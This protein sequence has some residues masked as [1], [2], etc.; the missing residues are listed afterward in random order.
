MAQGHGEQ[1]RG[2]RG[3]VLSSVENV[4]PE[5]VERHFHKEIILLTI[6]HRKAR[7]WAVA[8]LQLRVVEHC[9]IEIFFCAGGSGRRGLA[10]G[11]QA[12]WEQRRGIRGSAWLGEGGYS[13]VDRLS[14]GRAMVEERDGNRHG[15][16]RIFRFW[17]LRWWWAHNHARSTAEA[18]GDGGRTT[19]R[20]A[21]PALIHRS[22]VLH[23]M[24][25][26]T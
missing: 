8:R 22:C 21:Q 24:L 19:M 3:S 10:K 18:W 15:G 1:R 11:A 9:S 2:T 4:E 16:C 25:H 7:F 6:N 26:D 23:V 5:A 12:H 14:D 13:L 20:V 17:S